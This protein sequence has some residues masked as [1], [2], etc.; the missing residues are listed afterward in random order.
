MSKLETLLKETPKNAVILDSWLKQR[1]ISN[2]LK[3]KYLQ[4]G[5]LR[6]I[7]RGA[8]YL[9]DNLPNWQGAVSAMQGAGEKIH[10]G[11]KTALQLQGA[12]HFISPELSKLYLYGDS[13]QKLP[14]WFLQYDWQMQIYYYQTNFLP[15][16][17]GIENFSQEN[18]IILKTSSPERAILELLYLVPSNQG[19][20]EA[21]Y[22]IENLSTLRANL[23]QELLESCNSIKVKRLFFCLSEKAR[24]SWITL[25]NK[26]KID[27]GSGNR[28]IV[29]GGY[30]D[31]AY[32]IT[33]PKN[34]KD[35]ET[36]LF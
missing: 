16:D 32:N 18:G 19:I 3:Q 33:L 8:S 31:P 11:G 29:T 34:W 30:L 4:Y 21:Y 15:A 9:K 2:S 10:V 13:G 36:T 25:L 17:L 1:L 7:G 24:H 35:D 12:G 28:H 23:L 26:E 5:W 27:F 6:S 20:E 14:A 22:I